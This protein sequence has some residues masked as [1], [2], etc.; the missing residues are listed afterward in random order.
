MN[1][2]NIA[3]KPEYVPI[4]QEALKSRFIFG[5]WEENEVNFAGRHVSVKSNKVII[6][7]E[8]YILKKL[9]PIPLAKSRLSDKSMPIS[10]D[11]FEQ[12]SSMLYKMTWVAHQTRPEA[13][14][15]VSSLASRLK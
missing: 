15:I 12:F 5:K 4:F 9:L 2:L 7:Q 6:Y 10:E 14:D 1:N 8:K 3:S 11:E 13:S